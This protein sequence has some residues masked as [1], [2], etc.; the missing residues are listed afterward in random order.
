MTNKP[1]VLKAL[2]AL[3]ETNRWLATIKGKHVTTAAIY[4]AK[5]ELISQ[6]LREWID[7][8]GWQPIESAPKDEMVLVINMDLKL[9]PV[10][11][12]FYSVGDYWRNDSFDALQEC[13]THWQH[14]PDVVNS[15]RNKR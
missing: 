14:I 8:Q 3:E 13:P 15:L 1:P 12:E 4:Q 11:A 7:N 5:N 10:I 9:S 6:E 2:E